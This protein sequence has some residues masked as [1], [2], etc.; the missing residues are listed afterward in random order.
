MT[1]TLE[2]YLEII[3][4]LQKEWGAAS[5]TDIAERKGVKAPSVTYIL[6]K[7]KELDLVNYKKYRI[8]TLTAKG[9]KIVKNLEQAH[10]TLRWFFCLIGVDSKIADI[11]ACEIEHLAHPQTIERLKQFVDIIKNAPREPKWIDQLRAYQQT[12]S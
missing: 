8:V 4:D 3:Y 12:K 7:L 6:R 5:V 2:Q 1:K 10:E 11:D 9:L